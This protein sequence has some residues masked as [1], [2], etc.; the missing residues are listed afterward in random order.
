VWYIE[1][2][3]RYEHDWAGILAGIEGVEES[4]PGFGSSGCGCSSHLF[5]TER[6]GIFEEFRGLAGGDVKRSAA[7]RL[8]G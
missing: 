6:T 5:R 4:A 8:S 7:V 1:S 2:E 3:E